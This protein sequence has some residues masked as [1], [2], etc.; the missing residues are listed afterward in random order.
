LKRSSH[1]FAHF[2]QCRKLQ[3]HNRGWRKEETVPF[4]LNTAQHTMHLCGK[5]KLCTWHDVANGTPAW[6]AR[7][8]TVIFASIELLLWEIMSWDRRLWG[9]LAG[10]N[11]YCASTDPE[12]LCP[13]AEP[14]EQR[15]LT[16]YT[17][18][19]RLQKQKAKLNPHMAACDSTGY[20]IFPVLCDLHVSIFFKFYLSA[21]LSPSPVLLSEHQPDCFF[22]GLPF[23]VTLELIG[24]EVPYLGKMQALR[25]S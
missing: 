18:A 15:G 14:R 9:K 20:F 3:T 11:V 22:S 10:R 6:Q 5:K 19:S 13:K 23:L 8:K 7:R 1:T 17:V 16:L 12:D 21:L 2:L 25:N 4:Y 24:V